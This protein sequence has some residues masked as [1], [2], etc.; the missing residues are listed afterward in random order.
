VT[1]P[2]ARDRIYRRRGFDA[3]IIELC[4]RWYIS[5]RLSYR[6]LV[7]LMA[8]RGVAVSHTTIMRWVIRYVPEFE[9][10]WNRFARPVGRSWRVDET[11]IPIRGRWHY[12]YRAVDRQGK[13]VDFLLRPDRG[14][15]AAQAFFR[16]ALY[17]AS[18]RSAQ[19]YPRRP[20]A[21]SARFV[22]TAGRASALAQSGSSNLQV[23]QQHRRAGPPGNQ[24]TLCVHDGIQ[25]VLQRVDRACGS[26]AGSSDSQAPVL[27]RS[28]TASSPV[29]ENHVG[30]GDGVKRRPRKTAVSS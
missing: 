20:R 5:Y 28:R 1:K 19:S 10:R 12:L 11:Y 27:V 18:A 2:I 7:E 29:N 22:A 14:I 6:D 23:P 21:E 8:D 24:A 4:V 26:R 3:E 16:K 30:D 9:K 25:I 17:F 13:T 15:A